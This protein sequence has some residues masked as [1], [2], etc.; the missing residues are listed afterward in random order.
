MAPLRFPPCFTSSVAELKIFIKEM[1]PEASPPVLDTMSF[2]G[3]SLLKLKPVPPPD[4]CTKAVHLRLSNIPS[5]LSSTG[6]TKQAESCWT[7][8]PAFIKVGELGKK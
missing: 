1:G 3:L 2:L 6:K 8:V 7:E 4:L 5:M